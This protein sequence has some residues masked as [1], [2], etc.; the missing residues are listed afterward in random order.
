V[1]RRL[2][3]QVRAQNRHT[4][5][6]FLGPPTSSFGSRPAGG[7]GF[8]SGPASGGFGMVPSLLLEMPEVLFFFTGY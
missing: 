6:L 1:T 7:M 2:P 5:T 4:N 3:W 8:G